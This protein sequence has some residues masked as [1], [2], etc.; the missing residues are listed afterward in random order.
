MDGLVEFCIG[1]GELDDNFIITFGFQDNA[2][3]IL[4]TPKTV[5][6][7]FLYETN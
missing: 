7:N 5:I 4:S 3:F 2:A 1:M 6:K